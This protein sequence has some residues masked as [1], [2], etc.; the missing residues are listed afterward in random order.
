YRC[1]KF[2]LEGPKKGQTE[3]FIDRLPGF[4]DNIRSDG[5]GVFWIG[6]PTRWSLLGRMMIRFTY[7]RHVGILLSSLMPGGIDAALVKEG[8][9]LGVDEKGKAVALYSHQGLTGI[10]GGLR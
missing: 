3:S 2:W 4:P 1:R 10:T 7:L 5:E 6:L 9:V 8:S